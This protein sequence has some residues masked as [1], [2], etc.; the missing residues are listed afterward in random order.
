VHANHILHF[1][2]LFFVL[3]A[4]AKGPDGNTI[5]PSVRIVLTQ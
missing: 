1:F 3:H 2:V 5:G 4:P